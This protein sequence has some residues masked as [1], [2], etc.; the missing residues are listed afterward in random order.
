MSKAFEEMV[1]DIVQEKLNGEVIE[2][3]IEEKLKNAVSAA[4]D[5]IFR[6]SGDGKKMIEGKLK[7]IFI[8]ALERSDFSEYTKKL[9]IAL[10]EIIRNTALADNRNILEAFKELMTEPECKSI[11][12]SKIFE[13]YKKYVAANVDTDGLKAECE[14]GEPYY[15]HVGVSLEF[16]REKNAWFK[17]S[18]DYGKVHLRCEH[19]ENDELSFDLQLSK[20]E[21]NNVWKPLFGRS[22]LD[23][24]SLARLSDFE[25]LIIQLNRANVE[26]VVDIECG[27]DEVEP[28]EKPEWSLN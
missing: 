21:K 22:V 2:K 15:E 8:P 13:E 16:E 9:D 7:E 19:D 3:I 5:D 6:W 12:L 11:K 23:F 25:I 4:C 10:S 20:W 14:D 24:N 26:V 18:F 27:D 1:H 17:G 28:D